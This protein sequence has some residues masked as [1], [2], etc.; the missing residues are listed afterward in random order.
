VLKKITYTI[1]ILLIGVGTLN[2]KIQMSDREI[3]S[4][5]KG[6]V[7]TTKKM[8]QIVP[9]DYVSSSYD[10]LLHYAVRFRKP[11][12]VEYLV[13]Q[14]ILISRKGGLFDGTALQEALYYGHLGI[15]NYLID[16]GTFLNIRNRYGETALHIATKNGY[17]GI[18]NK[19][20]AR[21]ASKTIADG[22]G[23]VP[24][25]LIPNLSW[26]SRKEFMKILRTDKSIGRKSKSFGGGV[27][28]KYIGNRESQ[29]TRGVHHKSVGDR[30]V[31]IID[32][33]SK[34]DGDV[35]LGIDIE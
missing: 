26:S 19:L 7:P 16:M 22:N 18:V 29:Y 9:I 35:N 24:Y 20:V 17:L 23:R 33:K 34:I 31:V 3:V 10:T 8:L 30:D 11:K 28:M 13:R 4:A 15:A 2:S 5:I 1:F 21:G 27:Y 12:V 6:G 25:D 32:G 14:K